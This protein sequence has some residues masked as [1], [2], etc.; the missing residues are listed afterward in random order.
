MK[1]FVFIM[2]L[3]AMSIVSCQ[4]EFEEHYVDKR[5]I[6]TVDSL[7]F[8]PIKPPFPISLELDSIVLVRQLNNPYAVSNMRA[9]YDIVAPIMLEAGISKDDITTTH[10]Y[11]KFNPLNLNELQ[12]LK[13]QYHLAEFYEYPLDYEIRGQYSYHD[14]A[15]PDSIPTYQ[16]AAIDSLSWCS[17]P[18]LPINYDI[19]ERLYIPDEDIID[20]TTMSLL[21]SGTNKTNAIEAL[22]SQALLL[23]GNNEDTDEEG[24]TIMSSN[25][26]WIPAGRITV[27]DNIVN[28]QIPLVGV[29]VRARRWFTTHI[30]YTNE[31]GYY[32]CD[33][34]FKRPANYSIIWEGDGWNIRNGLVVQAYHN[35]PKKCG[36]WN[37][38][39]PEG[40]SKTLYYATIHRAAHRF[41]KGNTYGLTRPNPAFIENISYLESEGSNHGIY[42][43]EWG[44]DLFG[45]I[46]IRGKSEGLYRTV[47]QVLSTTFHELAHASHY[48]NNIVRFV[49]SQRIIQESWA[50][51]V[52]YYLTLME[53]TELGCQDILFPDIY[54]E[55]VTSDPLAIGL[56]CKEP[57]YLNRQDWV[58][59]ID[60]FYTPLFIDLMD[61]DN[62]RTR[63]IISEED[64]W[65][66]FPNDGISH[67]TAEM[68]EDI[69]YNIR[70][71]DQM[72]E[73]IIDNYLPTYGPDL[74]Y[75]LNHSSINNYFSVYEELY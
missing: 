7:V 34:T 66:L 28:D 75:G 54:I 41:I 4:R 26:E 19:L 30:G 45:D 24:N 52:R 53:Y 39:I 57:N 55:P 65:N 1:R 9:A 44:G 25:E 22:V 21:N 36:D 13:E 71:V 43:L 74:Y 33:G 51:F 73:Y 23:T 3:C 61:T 35:G 46:R 42:Y 10:F 58:A 68:I 50:D 49:T 27:Y 18:Q 14:P 60:S 31:N 62:Q 70:T 40:H 17:T 67:F 69:A 72:K 29:K 37:L 5:L 15:L 59:A 8:N 2:A 56:I 38:D 20:D 64:S 48:T 6:N 63:A 12:E 11:I 32:T 47:Q 16:Y